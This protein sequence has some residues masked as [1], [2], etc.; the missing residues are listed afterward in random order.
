MLIDSKLPSI[1]A[2]A[3]QNTSTFNDAK[4]QNVELPTGNSKNLNIGNNYVDGQY[5]IELK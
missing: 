4:V 2:A 3:D 5:F 1:I